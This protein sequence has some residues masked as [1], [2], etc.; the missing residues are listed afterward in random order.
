MENEGLPVS[1][2]FGAGGD[3]QFELGTWLGRHQA[4][5]C[6]ASKCSAADAF[7]LREIRVNKL[8]RSLD[9]SWEDFCTIHAGI[10][11]KTA[12]QNISRLEEFGDVYFNLS[13][14]LHITVPEFRALAPSIEDNTIEYEGRRIPI[15][16]AHTRQLIE[17]VRD[18]RAQLEKAPKLAKRD[19]YAVL[20]SALDQSIGNI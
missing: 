9:L 7:A 8:Y 13:Q 1:G 19:P 16:R 6:I 5:G 12:D 11:S 18:L 10:T 17:V 3:Q 15:T 20:K 14:V 2:P 4:M